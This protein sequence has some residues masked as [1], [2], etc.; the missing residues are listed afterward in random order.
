MGRKYRFCIE[1]YIDFMIGIE[2]I[3]KQINISF[4]IKTRAF[5]LKK[6]EHPCFYF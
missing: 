1:K 6:V 5:L 4:P 3:M 2:F